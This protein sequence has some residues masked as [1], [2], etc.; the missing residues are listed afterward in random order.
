MMKCHIHAIV[1]LVLPHVVLVRAQE[2]I[3][4][5]THNSASVT[6]SKWSPFSAVG[7]CQ[8]VSIYE[9]LM[10][11]A[12]YIDLRVGGGTGRRRRRRTNATTTSSPSIV[13]SIV[14]VH[15][16]LNGS[17]FPD[18]IHEM[19]NFLRDRDDGEFVIIDIQFDRNKHRLSS[20]QRF[21]LLEFVSHVFKDRLITHADATS[22]FDLKTVTLGE[23]LLDQ[24]KNVLILLNDGM[25]NCG[26]FY[27]DGTRYDANTIAKQFGC[28]W[29]HRYLVNQW[30]NSACPQTVLQKNE[31]FLEKHGNC[32]NKFVISQ[33]V[34]SPLPPKVRT[35]LL[36][37][38]LFSYIHFVTSERANEFQNIVD[39]LCLLLGIKSLR[40]VCLVRELYR[41]DLL[42]TSIR[43]TPDNRWSIVLLGMSTNVVQSGIG[44]LFIMTFTFSPNSF[45][46]T[47][48]DQ[49]SLIC[50][51]N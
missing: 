40:P 6:I 46:T 34:L 31:S 14:I 18:I 16:I 33:L 13:N 20:Q 7:I 8:N 48:H 37:T 47:S 29:N 45:F 39:A 12:R 1:I 30:H 43:N 26:D 10:R 5:G 36:F 2:L 42:E 32:K 3:L 27:H 23:L 19:D 41:T 24:K 38:C 21:H 11:G 35:W 51:H 49:I 9:Q 28:H 4:P 50:A 22:W 15:G 25:V 17:P 44:D